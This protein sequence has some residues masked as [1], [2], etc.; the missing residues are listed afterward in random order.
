MTNR[1]GSKCPAG[2]ANLTRTAD[3]LAASASHWP[4]HK[5]QEAKRHAPD[6]R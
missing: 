6:L 1:D 2:H 3:P 4:A 5:Q